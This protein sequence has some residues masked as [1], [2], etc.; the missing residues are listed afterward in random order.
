MVKLAIIILFSWILTACGLGDSNNVL[1]K[2]IYSTNK[3]KRAVLFLK[4]NGATSDNSLQVS[5]LSANHELS[6]EEAGNVFTVNSNH[7]STSQNENSINILWVSNDT[8]KIEYDKRLR[9]FI[10]ESNL[11]GVTI[12][13]EPK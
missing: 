10:K 5:I 13:Y 6:K 2:Q 8:L 12:L 3:K 9:T 11:E 1:L 4:E 7:D